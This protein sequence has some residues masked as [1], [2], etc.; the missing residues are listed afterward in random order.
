MSE[1]TVLVRKLTYIDFLVNSRQVG[2]GPPAEKAMRGYEAAMR[3][4]LC[5]CNVLVVEH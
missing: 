5:Y 2:H 3:A 1:G 4:R